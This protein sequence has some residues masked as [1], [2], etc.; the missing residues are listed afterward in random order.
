MLESFGVFCG[1]DCGDVIIAREIPVAVREVDRR[2]LLVDVG[3]D[4]G[5]INLCEE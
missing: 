2:V 3:T 1:G 5:L 4:L